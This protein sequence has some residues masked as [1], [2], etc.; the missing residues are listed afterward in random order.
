MTRAG[1]PDEQHSQTLL[2]LGVV[3]LMA[4]VLAFDLMLPLG[5][6]AGLPY[7]IPTLLSVWLR[8]RHA[9]WVVAG[10]CSVLTVAGIFPMESPAAAWI[11]ATNRALT[12]FAIWS[13]A[14]VGMLYQRTLARLREHQAGL[15]DRIRER[16]ADLAQ[17]AES[18]KNEVETRRAAESALQ[19]SRDRLQEA[20]RI[21][22]L[23]GWEY[24]LPDGPLR[25]TEGAERLFGLA[26]QDNAASLLQRIHGE[27]RALV[28]DL[29]QRA[30]KGDGRLTVECRLLGP[31][32]SLR[33]V[34]IAAER[35]DGTGTP[36]VLVGTIQDISERRLLEERL[37]ESQKLDSIGRLA[38]GIA[39]DFNNVLAV[40]QGQSEMALRKAKDCSCRRSLESIHGAA[41]R[42][43]NLTRQLLGFAR[44]QI[45]SPRVV[46]PN[47]LLQN[48]Q[49]M[50]ERLVGDDVSLRFVLDGAAGNVRMDSGQFEQIVMNLVGNARDAMPKGGSLTIETAAL[51]LDE[52]YV[53]DHPEA[54]VGHH[55]LLAVTD[56]GE[57]MS[58]ETRARIFEPFFTT[59]GVGRGTGLGLATVFGIV[60]QN[61]GLIGV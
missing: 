20:Q 59:K 46:S 9:P 25:L 8:R 49:G 4:A 52:S 23:A 6:A 41:D 50:L 55:V 31:D 29:L 24:P 33:W 16:T 54:Q 13:T 57:G 10:A 36:G 21:A 26:P 35:H 18:L 28:T 34:V 38:G 12:L 32:N 51:Y 58:P 61:G 42:G 5:I 22:M 43:S 15:E 56:T 19:T 3:V 30:R 47:A 1:Q 37:R 45:V 14:A 2:A 53:R 11:W 27:D 7:I 39:H 60:K 44:R 48:L 17:T 40:I